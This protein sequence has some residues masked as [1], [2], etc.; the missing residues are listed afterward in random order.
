M[1]GLLVSPKFLEQMD[2]CSNARSVLFFAGVGRGEGEAVVAPGI[3]I[4]FLV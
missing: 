1:C 4:R 2:V 3:H